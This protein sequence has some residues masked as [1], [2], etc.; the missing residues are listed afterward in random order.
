ML[1]LYHVPGS[2][3]LTGLHSWVCHLNLFSMTKVKIACQITPN[4]F[5]SDLCLHCLSFI[6]LNFYH[7]PGSSNLTGLHSWVCHLNLFSMT[8]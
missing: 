1:N 8:K 2:S 6:M 4:Q 7:V 5:A 3:N